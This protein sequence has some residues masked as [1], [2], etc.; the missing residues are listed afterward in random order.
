MPSMFGR[1]KKKENILPFP[2]EKLRVIHAAI[3]KQNLNAECL[4]F[5]H[6]RLNHQEAVNVDLNKYQ[7]IYAI[8]DLHADY[9]TFYKRLIDFKIITSPDNLNPDQ[10]KDI[11]EI[12]KLTD[13]TWLE[14]NTLLVICGDI[15]DG[16]RTFFDENENKQIFEVTDPKGIFELYLHIFLKNLKAKALQSESDVICVLGNHDLM[17][18]SQYDA[19]VHETAKVFFTNSEKRRTI[20]GP[21]YLNNF[22]F[23][24][25]LK[26]NNTNQTLV[27]AHASLHNEKWEYLPDD[28]T[29][30]NHTSF[31]TNLQDMFVNKKTPTNFQD[32]F[33]NKK[34]PTN[35]QEL[36][37]EEDYFVWNRAYKKLR[38]NDEKCKHFVDN[39]T[40]IVGHCTCDNQQYFFDRPCQKNDSCIYSKCHKPDDNKSDGHKSDD[41]FYPKLIMIDT[42]MSNCFR[43]P[44][45]MNEPIEILKIW[46]EE[47]NDAPFKNFSSLFFDN[48]T[49]ALY[50]LKDSAG[51]EI[52]RV[53]EKSL[54]K[55]KESDLMFA[56]SLYIYD[57]SK[58]LPIEEIL[59]E[60]ALDIKNNNENNKNMMILIKYKPLAA[61]R[62][63]CKNCESENLGLATFCNQCGNK[64]IEYDNETNSINDADADGK[65]GVSENDKKNT[66][67]SVPGGNRRSKRSRRYSKNRKH[68][69]KYRSRRRK[70]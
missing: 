38:Q 8:S 41:N 2:I 16:K 57:A 15:I 18:F 51:T 37:N 59:K 43:G 24:Y 47:V 29:L 68:K 56:K 7:N 49:L 44:D 32:M 63:K 62:K 67:K 61:L 70:N 5:T 42:M 25:N 52:E 33:V 19:Y 34:T 9:S 48:S 54:D 65:E 1:F 14:K 12:S 23:A 55:L 58:K 45:G 31:F 50:N 36:L 39:T 46:K 28:V 20:L 4:Q 30:T 35:F 13:F 21:F 69:K 66:P 26:A 6:L 53:I 40:V 27:F 17:L 10:V 60:K 22:Y 3:E 11:Y 64:F